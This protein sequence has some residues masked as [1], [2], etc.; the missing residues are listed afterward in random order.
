MRIP[1]MLSMFISFIPWIVYWVLSGIEEPI[2][3]ALGLVLSLILLTPQIIKKEINIFDSASFLYFSIALIGWYIL[4]IDA[5]IEMSGFLGYFTMFLLA[6]VSVIIKRP[7]TLQVSKRDYPRAYWDNPEFIKVNT[8]ITMLWSLIYIS[9][10]FLFQYSPKPLNVIITNILIVIGIILSIILPGKIVA[11]SVIRDLNK[12][13]WRVPLKQ[14]KT[15]GTNEFDVIIVGAGIGGLTCGALLAKRGY[16]VLVLEQHYLVGG[17]CSA[18]ERMGFIFNTGVESISGIWENGP[19]TYLLNKLGLNKD[20]YFVKNTERYIYRGEIIDIPDNYWDYAKYLAEKFPDEKDNIFAFFRDAWNAY[21]ELYS[22]VKKWGVPLPA[23]LYIKLYGRK[24]L[25]EYPRRKP[26]LS[27]WL[28]KTFKALLDEYFTNKDLKVLLTALLPYVGTKPEKTSALSA[29][30]ACLGYYMH[31][32]Y[33]TKG[34]AQKFADCLKNVIEENGGTILLEHKVDEILIEKGKVYGVRV[35]E[36]IFKA[37]IVVANANAKNVFLKLIDK[38]H[39]SHE[40][41]KYI[42]SLKM[43]T[44]AFMV[45][46]GVDMDLSSYPVLIKN[47]DEGYSIVI[48][49]NADPN[50]APSGKAS[51]SI[52]IFAN[53]HDFPDRTS[54]EYLKKKRELTEKYIKRAEE[55]IPEL[56]KHII[57]KDAATPKTF[58]RYTLTPEGAIYSFDQ[59]IRTK[60]PFFKTPIKGLYLVGASTFPGG[61]I[62]AVVIS[63][64]ICANDICNWKI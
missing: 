60:R 55:I 9:N 18:F 40:Y 34:S 25:L 62:E 23:Y 5:F 59:S 15:R 41:L 36:Q 29:L 6:V 64:I 47:L 46:L 8:L 10:A 13:D 17:Y 7:Y 61:G 38:K 21:H 43:S 27:R 39:L 45:F 11:Y 2:G 44:S 22:D 63:G 19:I 1:G 31:P 24:A 16:K 50:L 28:N 30:T 51:V 35:G 3:I 26:T 42:Q 58:E 56:S 12:Y 20:D 14:G 52:I 57:F 54:K 32:N 49:S 33:F 4:N 37:P 53:Y 48:N